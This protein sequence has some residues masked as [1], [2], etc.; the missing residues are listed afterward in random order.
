MDDDP[1]EDYVEAP[2][3]PSR[4]LSALFSSDDGI[5]DARTLDADAAGDSATVSAAPSTPPGVVGRLAAIL[6][7][8]CS[9]RRP[10]EQPSALGTS[11]ASAAAADSISRE[12]ARARAALE[13]EGDRLCD[14]M[15]DETCPADLDDLDCVEFGDVAARA[16][17]VQ[18][19]ATNPWHAV[20]AEQ[21][22]PGWLQDEPRRLRTIPEDAGAFLNAHS[23]S[24]T[25]AAH[26]DRDVLA[27]DE[28]TVAWSGPPTNAGSASSAAAPNQLAAGQLPEHDFEDLDDEVGMQDAAD[29]MGPMPSPTDDL[30]EEPWEAMNLNPHERELWERVRTRPIRREAAEVQALKL[31]NSV[32]NRLMKLHPGVSMRTAEATD[33][34]NLSA[35]VLMRAVMAA[36]VRGTK[37]GSRVQ[38]EDIRQACLAA[39]EL[40]FL[41][42]LQGSLDTSATRLHRGDAALAD[43][44]G[45][46]PVVAKQVVGDDV[47]DAADAKGKAPS[48]GASRL[49]AMFARNAT[50]A[51]EEKAA[52]DAAEQKAGNEEEA[53]PSAA[54]V[55]PPPASR[56]SDR[57]VSTRKRTAPA[58][59]V[60]NAS[61]APR[62]EGKAAGAAAGKKK[63][64]GACVDVE[65]EGN[66]GTS[67]AALA[68]RPAT[69]VGGR[70]KQPTLMAFFK[71]A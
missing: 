29:M 8:H 4:P 47:P 15:L 2:R 66:K 12:K 18:E 35:V 46:I 3:R 19:D 58:A 30:P 49:G 57:A 5:F 41:L 9:E 25:V 7:A 13:L 14:D 55:T 27:E 11:P 28:D 70:A 1:V 69:N 67:D 43:D 34:V 52:N 38:F 61:K 10:Q 59:K 54:G 6:G 36:A 22:P 33:V 56:G 65:I 39:R 64:N 68:D 16:P 21:A 42:P 53:I 40:Q 32:V 44:D 45:T 23:T 48:A 24:A 20:E 63:S 60:G 31:P 62:N 17:A 71:K 50:S 26:L 51:A 37:P